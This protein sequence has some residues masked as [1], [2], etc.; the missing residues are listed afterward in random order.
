MAGRK[1]DTRQ[2]INRA[3]LSGI[4][5]AANTTLDVILAE[6]G[7]ATY[8]PTASVLMTR[9]A[10]G[11]TAANS[12]IPGE[13]STVTSATTTTLTVA[14]TYTQQFTGTTTQT[15]ALPSALTLVLGQQYYITNR[16]TGTVTVNDN[17]G[18]LLQ[19]MGSN[20]QTIF[21]VTN[22]SSSS[23][24]WDVG[25]SI[26]SALSNPMT[27]TGDMIY[28]G[29]GGTPTRLPVGSTGQSLVVSPGGIPS[30]I[31][32]AIAPTQSVCTTLAGTGGFPV[33][34]T[35][36]TYTT[37]AG[38]TAIKIRMIGG[39]GGGGGAGN[40]TPVAG[41]TG[42]GTSFGTYI[43]AG[44]GGGQTG[45]SSIGNSAGGTPGSNSGS[46]TISIRGDYGSPGIWVSTSTGSP[47]GGNGGSGV[48]GGG[49]MGGIDDGTIPPTAGL[50]NSGGGGGGGGSSNLALYG[51]GGGGASGSYAEQLISSP[52]ATYSFSLGLGGTAGTNVSGSPG[53]VGGSGIIIVD[54]YY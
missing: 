8:L 36:G 14:S 22:I 44:G 20:T 33:T 34:G 35:S 7:D 51:S 9:D 49:G 32:I 45:S 5:I 43:A 42:G 16:S 53:T 52:A 27:T 10:N 6:I 12:F 46:P 25:Y 47:T 3:A 48:F 29:A 26:S 31:T 18:G 28:G 30:W 11:N 13:T 38:C 21:T 4:G 37:P 40:N 54:E 39:G 23:G 24:S 19:V 50:A 1:I 17:G 15:V 41:G 2:S